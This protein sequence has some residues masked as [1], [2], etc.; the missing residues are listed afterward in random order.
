MIGW[1]QHIRQRDKLA[2]KQR[3]RLHRKA[4]KLNLLDKLPEVVRTVW[5]A[6]KRR[7]FLTRIAR[8]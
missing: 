6:K 7:N 1:Q 8:G 4:Q 2:K 5:G 3:E